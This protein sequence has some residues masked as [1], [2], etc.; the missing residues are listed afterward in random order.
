MLMRLTLNHSRAIFFVL[1]YLFSLSLL[2]PGSSQAR[3]VSQHQPQQKHLSRSSL[4]LP[5]CKFCSR[6]FNTSWNCK[7][8]ELIHTGVKPFTC[9]FC[10]KSFNQRI[11]LAGHER[12]HTGLKP[13]PCQFCGILFSRKSGA[14]SHEL[15]CKFKL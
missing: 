1:F 3:S 7:R 5:R 10:S 8:H 13:Y 6:E 4:D 14:R 11:N 12:L 2:E 15:V 9:K